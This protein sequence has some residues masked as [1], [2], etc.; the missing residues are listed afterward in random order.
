MKYL[1]LMSC[2]LMALLFSC[3]Q[4]NPKGEKEV[5][6][7]MIDWNTAHSQ[8][9]SPYLSNFYMPVVTYYDKERTRAQVQEHKN[10]LFQKFPNY[11]QDILNDEMTITKVGV[12]YLVTFIKRVKYNGVEANY[13]SF[14]SVINRNGNFKISREGV[15]E[16]SENLDAPIFPS[17]EDDS[18]IMANTRKLY[19]DFNGDGLSDYATV[20]SPV[21]KN[22]LNG[23]SQTSESVEC[24]GECHSVIMFSN[25]DLKP[26]TVEGAYQSQLENLKDLNGDGADEIGFWDIKPT[27]KSLYIFNATNGALLTEPVMINTAVH[28]NLKLVDVFKKTGTN[29][30]TITKSVQENG[31][32]ILKSEVIK[33]D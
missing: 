5:R 23:E 11:T 8:L 16:N 18:I 20:I 26:I 9:K 7:F 14:L 31:N 21:I 12:N 33:L 15:D 13:K 2:L 3:N 27:S 28:K 32:W 1:S 25:K 6:E 19:G 10:I 17:A 24:V 22:S 30:I 29:K 4:I